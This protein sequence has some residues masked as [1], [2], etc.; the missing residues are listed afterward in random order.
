MHKCLVAGATIL[1][2]AAPQAAMADTF[3]LLI[4][5]RNDG[6]RNAGISHGWKIPM[7]SMEQCEAAGLK[8]MGDNGIHGRIF[9]N[10]RYICITGK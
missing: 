6:L 7:N 1:S 5:G 3:W 4:A 2:I 10:L 9:S 8:V